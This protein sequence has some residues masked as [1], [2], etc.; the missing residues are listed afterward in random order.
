[1]SETIFR[2]THHVSMSYPNVHVDPEAPYVRPAIDPTVW[3]AQTAF[4]NG[5]VTLKPHSSVWYGCVLRG[6]TGHIEVGEESNIQD[7][8]VLHT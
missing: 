6:D 5:R 3:V 1:M 4:V 7:C 2:H 8:S